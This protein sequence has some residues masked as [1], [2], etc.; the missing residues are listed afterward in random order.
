MIPGHIKD[1]L[2]T[3]SS[4]QQIKFHE[5]VAWASNSGLAGSSLPVDYGRII[6]MVKNMGGA[7]IEPI[8][9]VVPD[10]PEFSFHDYIK[11]PA[12]E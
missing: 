4:A 2:N 9:P 10:D 8:A 3:L 12:K 11:N 7:P 1:E 6:E 5:L